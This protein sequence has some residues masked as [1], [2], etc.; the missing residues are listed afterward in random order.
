[1]FTL[2]HDDVL[3]TVGQKKVIELVA[4]DLTAKVREQGLGVTV[5]ASD[6]PDVGLLRACLLTMRDK[7][8]GASLVTDKQAVVAVATARRDAPGAADVEVGD[9]PRLQKSQRS[10]VCQHSWACCDGGAW[11]PDRSGKPA[12]RS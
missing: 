6:E 10:L 5:D 4:A 8:L 1:M 9:L 11:L 2:R 12:D 3:N 7:Q